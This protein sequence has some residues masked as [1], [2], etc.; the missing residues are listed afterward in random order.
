M[1]QIQL[2]SSVN[3]IQLL[4]MIDDG[5]AVD[6]RGL[7]E[8][9]LVKRLRKLFLSLN[10]KETG[11]HVFLL[12]SKAFP[13]LETVGPLIRS[14]MQLQSQE[15]HQND[16]QSKP[17]DSGVGQEHCNANLSLPNEAAGGHN[18]N[19]S[20]SSDSATTYDANLSLPAEEDTGPKKRLVKKVSAS[21][22]VILHREKSLSLTPSLP[23]H[24]S[25]KEL[26]FSFF[27]LR[28]KRQWWWLSRWFLLLSKPH[29][30]PKLSYFNLISF[31]LVQ[32]DWSC[33]AFCRTT[34]CRS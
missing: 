14:Q 23:K 22:F 11:D 2:T 24:K 32:G 6:I 4:Q 5:Q 9:L 10:L 13:T 34:C 7:S 19:L 33:N 16:E 15:L 25:K 1:S 26:H 18:A 29:S 31:A 27:Y 20:L 17:L 28:N 3:S 12:P 8:K 30:S 21:K